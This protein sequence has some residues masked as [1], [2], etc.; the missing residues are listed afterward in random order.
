MCDDLPSTPK[1]GA[2][3]LQDRLWQ[4]VLDLSEGRITPTEANRLTKEAGRELRR[5]EV[6][7]R[8]AK[9]GQGVSQR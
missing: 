9:L 1:S 5:I 8:A 2:E 3:V 4:A 7:L 6:Q